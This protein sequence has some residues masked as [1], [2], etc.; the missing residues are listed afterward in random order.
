MRITDTQ[1]VVSNS[2]SEFDNTVCLAIGRLQDTGCVV[3]ITYYPVA[4]NGQIH[5]TA[6]IIGRGGQ[7]NE[8]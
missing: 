1:I 3:E 4:S 7:E 8:A 6:M 5:Y 2:A